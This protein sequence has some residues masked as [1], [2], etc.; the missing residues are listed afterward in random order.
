MQDSEDK[1]S[2]PTGQPEDLVQITDGINACQ[3]AHDELPRRKP[4]YVCM[5]VNARYA[6]RTQLAVIRSALFA[7]LIYRNLGPPGSPCRMRQ[8]QKMMTRTTCARHEL[9]FSVGANDARMHSVPVSSSSRRW[10]VRADGQSWVVVGK[11]RADARAPM[12]LCLRRAPTCDCSSTAQCSRVAQSSHASRGVPDA[13][14]PTAPTAHTQTPSW[15]R[16]LGAL[17]SQLHDSSGLLGGCSAVVGGTE[18]EEG[19]PRNGNV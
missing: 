10:A 1:S 12:C 18:E 2:A 17:G 7:R 9:K 5:H 16:T 13:A 15:Q 6:K 19:A 14:G 8:N 11:N 3:C 4:S